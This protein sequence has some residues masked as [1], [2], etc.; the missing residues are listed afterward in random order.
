MEISIR[1][2]SHSRRIIG[3]D[4]SIGGEDQQQAGEIA[5]ERTAVETIYGESGPVGQS[6]GR[7]ERS[8]NSVGYEST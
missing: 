3:Q 1:K 4:D 5:G 6:I 2:R 7:E 8:G